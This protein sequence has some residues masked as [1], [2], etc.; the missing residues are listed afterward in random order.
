M[1]GLTMRPISRRAALAASA[2]AMPAIATFGSRSRAADGVLR[3]LIDGNVGTVDPVVTTESMAIQ[4]AFMVYD[5]L[6]ATDAA[7]VPKPQMI[8][9]Y[10]RAADGKSWRFALR[11]GLKFHDGS[12]VESADVIASLRRWAARKPSGQALMREVED[13]R[14]IDAKSFEIRLKRPFEVMLDV[15]ADPLNALCIMRR[16]DAATDPATPVTTSVGSGPFIF[17][18]EGWRP[19]DKAVYRR[20]PNYVARS[21]PPD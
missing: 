7:T 21:E 15:L 18:Q 16:A 9:A 20:N 6:F 12:P 8:G 1:G 11:D 17:Q 4:H 14:A 10:E 2:L 19:G 3:V 13:I 5:Q